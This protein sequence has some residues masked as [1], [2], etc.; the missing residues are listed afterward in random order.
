MCQW[1]KGRAKVSLDQLTKEELQE[2]SFIEIAFEIMQSRKQPI[3]FY[4]LIK[5]IGEILD[6]SEEEMKDK[7]SQF[8]TD[9]N[10]DGRFLNV[11][12]NTWGLNSWYP[13]EQVE[14]EIVPTVT[15]KKKKSKKKLDDGFDDIEEEDL[16]D[17]DDYDDDLDED[18]FLDDDDLDEDEVD[19]EEDFEEEIP[20]ED[21]ELLIDEFDDD[22][23][24]DELDGFITDDEEEEEEEE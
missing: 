4:D 13:I 22:E 1:K 2:M 10:I 20:D 8:Y 3:A 15:K 7:I 16:D 21:D 19:D 14:D 12:D 23:A 6:I 5:Q 11:G 17:L 24:D 18:E 9:L